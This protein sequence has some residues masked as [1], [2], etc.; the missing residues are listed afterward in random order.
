MKHPF[1][2]LGYNSSMQ[3]AFAKEADIEGILNL[4]T[5]IYRVDKLASNSAWALK[6]QL[7]EKCCD[8]LVVKKDKQIIATATIYH[9][10]VAARGRPYALLEGL[11][12]DKKQRHHGIG[13]Q[14]FKKCIEIARQKNCYKMIFTSG[15]DRK[16][17][18]KF[19]EKLGF[20]KWGLEF[21]KNL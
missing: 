21:R 5:Q 11:V 14:L 17:A 19:Y 9:I 12:V 20:K 4:Q 2:Y 7:K 13:T 3:I 16:E 15:T 1:F 6:D 8:I 10:K 18:H